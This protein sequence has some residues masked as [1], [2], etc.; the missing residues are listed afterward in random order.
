MSLEAVALL[1]IAIDDIRAALGC[2]DAAPGTVCTPQGE[3]LRARAL[4]AATELHLGLPLQE[5]QPD[6]L[7]M[8]LRMALGPALDQHADARGV[9]IYP[10]KVAP[11][12]ASYEALVADLAELGDWVQPAAAADLEGAMQALG[13]A[14][15]DAMMGQLAS[16]LGDMLPPGMAQ[17][18]GGGDMNAMLQQ[19]MAGAQAILSDP[20]KAQQMMNALGGADALQ[21]MAA[22][23][24]SGGL[25]LGSLMGQAQQL[26]QDQPDLADALRQATGGDDDED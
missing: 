1:D 5:V 24:Q 21:N 23:A 12:A 17:Q 8:A 26:V 19:A 15:L 25:D 16:Q 11:E 13:G 7:G 6:E 18:M 22:G 14:P 3:S 10:A 4:G 9:L 2:T 20:A